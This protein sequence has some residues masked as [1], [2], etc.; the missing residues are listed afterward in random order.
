MAAGRAKYFFVPNDVL[1]IFSVNFELEKTLF[2]WTLFV[3]VSLSIAFQWDRDFLGFCQASQFA[4]KII[5]HGAPDALLID[6][7]STRLARFRKRS[8]QTR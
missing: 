8:C 7:G 5:E 4:L 6:S 2:R 3:D 1:P